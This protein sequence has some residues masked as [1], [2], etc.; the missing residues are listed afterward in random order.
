MNGALWALALGGLL[1]VYIV[2]RRIAPVYLGYARS[3]EDVAARMNRWN[4]YLVPHLR[5]FMGLQG[6]PVALVGTFR[7]QKDEREYTTATWT[8]EPSLMADVDYIVLAP[9]SDEGEDDPEVLGFIEANTLRELLQ[10]WAQPWEKYGHPGWIYMWSDD[11][12][13]H[14]LIEAAMNPE[15]FRARHALAMPD[16]GDES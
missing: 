10:G 1:A 15:E 4:M 6:M 2:G 8:F 3:K 16:D 5:Q 11:I 12:D 9:T 7:S 13:E 14:A